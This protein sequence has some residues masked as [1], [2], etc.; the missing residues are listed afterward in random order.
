MRAQDS[1]SAAVS[2]VDIVGY[3]TVCPQ[4]EPKM[5][6]LPWQSDGKSYPAYMCDDSPGAG[7]LPVGKLRRLGRTQKMALAAS[8]KALENFPLD[9]V[10]QEKIAVTVGTGLGAMGQ[11]AKFLE[12]MIIN[13]E[14]R[15]KPAC[16]I[17]SVHNSTASQIALNFGLKA[18]AHTFTQDSISFD[19]ALW[20]AINI[21]RLKRAD[22]VLS[23][24]VD[25]L[26]PYLIAFG[27]AYRWWQSKAEALSPMSA[28]KSGTGGTIAGEGAA[29]FLLSRSE[30]SPETP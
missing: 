4:S 18:E 1:N 19:L 20:H 25:E 3:A 22:Y 11:T 28:Q 10:P 29:A 23:C 15:P 21:L 9:S 14:G 5:M 30:S 8:S 26:S 16:F 12:N 7:I 27:Q 13:D 24:G 2:A 6:E 17:N